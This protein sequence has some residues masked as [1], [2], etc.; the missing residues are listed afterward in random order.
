MKRYETDAMV[1]ESG[2]VFV[3]AAHHTVASRGQTLVAYGLGACVGIALYDDDAH[4]GGIAHPILPR[5]GE[6]TSGA[7]R[8]FVDSAIEDLLR[9][10]VDAGAGY[11]SIRAWIVGG[12]Q[13]FDL[14]ALATGVA[15]RN[16]EVARDTLERLEV[17][18][19][20]EDVG[21][22][23]GRTLELD[24]ERGEVSVYTVD[25]EVRQL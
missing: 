14:E 10:V 17:E 24:T 7:R 9:D 5:L 3:D 4:V 19:A 12:A 1:P 8:K 23:Y 6:G 15:E 2:R 18:I 25:D 22:D 21:G 16:A 11:A 13:L 20:G